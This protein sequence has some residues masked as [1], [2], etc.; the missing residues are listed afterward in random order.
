MRR[1]RSIGERVEHSGRILLA[2]LAL[3]TIALGHST[4]AQV[5]TLLRSGLHTFPQHHKARL[6]VVE[7]GAP[8]SPSRVVI[9][10]RDARD[11]VVARTAAVLRRGEPVQLDVPVIDGLSQLRATVALYTAAGS[12]PSTTVEDIDELVVVPKVVC[13]PP[14]GRDSP[15]AFCPGW[16]VTSF[17]Q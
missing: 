10:F 3:I 14:S 9:D 12:R 4:S 1:K 7:L 13:G 8:L 6:T 15:Q 17:V 16:E 5:G 2:T 11:R